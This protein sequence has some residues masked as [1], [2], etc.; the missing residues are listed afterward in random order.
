M[1]FN[2]DLD[3]SDNSSSDAEF[4]GDNESDKDGL[5][6]DEQLTLTL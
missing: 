1:D 4:Q 2:S 6:P 5:D 3:D